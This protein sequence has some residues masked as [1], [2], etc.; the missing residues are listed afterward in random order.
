MKIVTVRK[1]E[2]YCNLCN[3]QLEVGKEVLQFWNKLK[4]EFRHIL[5]QYNSKLRKISL[6][7]YIKR[8]KLELAT[9]KNRVNLGLK[10]KKHK[11]PRITEARKQLRAY[12]RDLIRRS[13][14]IRGLD[15]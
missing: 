3:E 4:I 13:T 10:T 7:E 12:R 2:L 9:Y 1:E 14:R 5:C 11:K 15:Y 6:E 8:I